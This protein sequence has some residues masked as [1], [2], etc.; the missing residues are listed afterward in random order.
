VIKESLRHH[1]AVA[2]PLERIVPNGGMQINGHHIPEGTIVGVNAWVVHYDTSV[3]GEDAG[4][5]RPE[6]WID[7]GSEMLKR[8]EKSFFAVSLRMQL[9]HV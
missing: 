4:L 5:F 3:F 9:L 7:D 8:M 1:P 6:R 2:L